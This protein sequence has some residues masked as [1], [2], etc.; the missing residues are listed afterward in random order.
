MQIK[1]DIDIAQQAVLEPIIKVAASVGIQED[2]I[3]L[4]GR[5]KGKLSFGA[6]KRLSQK[7]DGK[8]VLVTS[9]NPTPAGEG[10]TLTTIG[11]AQGLQALGKNA[12]VA[13]REPSMGPVFGMKGGAAGGG[14]AQ[15]LPME[16]INLHFTGDMHAITAANN[17]LAA[18]IDNHLQ[19]GNELRLDSRRIV[20][21]RVLDMNDRALRHTVIGMGGMNSGIPREEHFMI[22]VASEIM[23]ILC[24]ATDIADLKRRMAAIIVGYDMDGKPVR[25]EQLQVTGAMAVLLKDAIKPNLVQTIEHTPALIHG[26]P[27]A[28]IAHG[29]NSIMATKMALKMGDI[30]ITEAGFGADLGAEKFFHIVCANA[31]FAPH[32]VVVVVTVRALKMHGGVARDALDQ[33]NVIAVQAGLANL[34]KH[35]D[36]LRQFGVPAIVGMN[37]FAADTTEEVQAIQKWCDAQHIPM[38]LQTC[39]RDGGKG[40]RA[41]AQVVIDVLQKQ[42]KASYQPLYDVHDSIENKVRAIVQKVYGGKDVAFSAQA[43][44]EIQ[45]L[46]ALGKT[47]LPICMAKTQYSLSDDPQAKGSPRDFVI[48]IDQVRLCAGA[49]FIVCQTR[50]I[51]VMPGLPKVPA[52]NGVDIDENGKIVGLF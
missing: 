47:S 10:K 25:A 46:V 33:A 13:L 18:A 15:V 22:T 42:D 34:A 52:A 3:E 9:I 11:L 14:Y 12:V 48:T 50:N 7:Q 36:T 43:K 35:M 29:C 28:N 4:Y 31:G 24:L 39:H 26:G 20:W 45:Q 44:K 32:A 21:K 2:E 41:L 51:L 6:M 16:D 8:L 49:G 19:Q 27:F 40:G 17:L 38:A 1:S 37:H 30:A 23:A 5:Y